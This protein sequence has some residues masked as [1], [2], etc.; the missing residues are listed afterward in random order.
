[1]AE[2]LYSERVA[3]QLSFDLK[4]TDWSE[5]SMLNQFYRSGVKEN[6][7]TLSIDEV[8]LDDV[9]HHI[10]CV[11]NVDSDDY[12][13]ISLGKELAQLNACKGFTESIQVSGEYFDFK[14]GAQIRVTGRTIE[15][16]VAA[17]EVAPTPVTARRRGN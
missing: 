12:A 4:E 5:V 3:P 10:Y 11:L 9:D 16:R 8:E 2:F 17:P 15:F 14:P 1:M 6:K 13:G 7:V